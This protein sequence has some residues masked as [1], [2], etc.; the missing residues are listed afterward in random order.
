MSSNDHME[1]WDQHSE[2]ADENRQLR[3][4]AQNL[5]TCNE[6]LMDKLKEVAERNG[7]LTAQVDQLLAVATNFADG[8]GI[9]SSR[10]SGRVHKLITLT[11]AI[12]RKIEK[13][14]ADE[15]QNLQHP[16]GG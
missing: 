4:Q 10:M 6:N 1:L 11:W 16:A 5:H 7:K 3:E 14:E 12:A 9:I 8:Y 15:L 13:E 2:L